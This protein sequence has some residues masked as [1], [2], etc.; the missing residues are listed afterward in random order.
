MGGYISSFLCTI[1]AT[2][3]PVYASFKA[4]ETEDKNDDTQWLTYWIVFS[5]FALFESLADELVFWVPFYYELK[6]LI[7]IALQIPQLQLASTLYT[8]YLRPILKRNEAKIDSAIGEASEFT[9]KAIHNIS[10]RASQQ[11]ASGT[12][13]GASKNE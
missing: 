11:I 12:V 8:V 4:L 6:L 2:T 3:Y 7:L 9:E 1:L 10:Q 5:V 13:L